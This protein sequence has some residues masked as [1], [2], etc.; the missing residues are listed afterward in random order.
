MYAKGCWIVIIVI[1]KTK[2]KKYERRLLPLWMTSQQANG[3]T[4][5]YTQAWVICYT[6]PGFSVT[7]K[8][9]I[10]NNWQYTLN[11]INFKTSA[12]KAKIK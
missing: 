12:H 3:G 8:N 2:R 5:G 9:N 10:Q 4:L 11:Q 6:K 1:L 7:I